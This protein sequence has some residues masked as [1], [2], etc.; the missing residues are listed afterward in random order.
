MNSRER[1][2]ATLDFTGPDRLPTDFWPV[3]AAWAGR[4]D[5]FRA[6]T[7]RYPGDFG[8]IP[9]TNIFDICCYTRGV[10]IDN[11]GCEWL[12]LIDG[13][14]GEVK[15]APL[16][17]Y[18]RLRDYTWPSTAQAPG[19]E[20]AAHT[21]RAAQ[22][23][24]FLLGNAGDPFERMQCLRGPEALFTDLADDEC[25]EV[26]VLRDRVFALVRENVEL[27]LR[28]GVDAIS[29]SDDWGSQQRLLIHPR[30]WRE[31]FKPKYQE[32]FDLVRDAGKRIFFHSDGYILDIY[33]DLIALGVEALNSQVWCMGLDALAPFA[34]TLTFW[35]E[36]DRQH[37]LPHGAPAEIKRDARRMVEA[38]YRNGGLIGQSSVD[39]MSSLENIE[40]ALSAWWEIPLPAQTGA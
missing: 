5:A 10:T 17:D 24:R 1:V 39:G 3:P 2:Y 19:W 16:A 7:A 22:A 29:F 26:Y 6:I 31:F 28:T 23:D 27:L 8:G 33:P 20:D 35:G 11:W 21:A 9:F 40:A 30:R 25:G 12:T 32:L 36:L 4:E 34:G 37:V 14:V 13:M 15:R 18:A 38:F